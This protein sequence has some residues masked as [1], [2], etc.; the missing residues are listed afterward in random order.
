ML[1]QKDNMSDYYGH[2]N[3]SGDA[4]Q[5]IAAIIFHIQPVALC[6]IKE[7]NAASKR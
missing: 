1:H 3:V 4:F 2:N 7:H 6:A 5:D